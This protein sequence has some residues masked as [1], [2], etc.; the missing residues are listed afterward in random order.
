M[1]SLKA[2]NEKNPVMKAFNSVNCPAIS[3]KSLYIPN[4]LQ[5]SMI[6]NP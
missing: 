5:T 3:K 1:K 6:T 4:C 2:F